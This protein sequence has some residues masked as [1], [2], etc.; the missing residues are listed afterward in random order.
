[1]RVRCYTAHRKMQSFIGQLPG[2]GKLPMGIVL[3]ILQAAVLGVGVFA[4]FKTMS[5]W[6]PWVAGFGPLG[7]LGGLAGLPGGLAVALRKPK[8]GG[9]WVWQAALGLLALVAHQ[10]RDRSEGRRGG[11]GFRPGRRVWVS[12][13][14]SAE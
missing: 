1:M 3:T 9:R 2:G 4:M 7:Y 14:V 11:R 13:W 10:V 12:E 8:V 6:G 5:L